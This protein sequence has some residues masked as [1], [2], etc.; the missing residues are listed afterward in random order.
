[1]DQLKAAM[2]PARYTGCSAVQVDQFLKQNVG[3]VLEKYKDE[4]GVSVEITV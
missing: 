3:P 4:L 2:E 1:M